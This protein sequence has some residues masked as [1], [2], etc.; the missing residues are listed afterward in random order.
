MLSVPPCTTRLLLAAGLLAVLGAGLAG[1]GTN[2]VEAPEAPVSSDAS[3]S[4]EEPEAAEDGDEEAAEDGEEDA[5]ERADASGIPVLISTDSSTGLIG[6]WRAGRSD[7]DDG[8]AIAMAHHA[9]ELDLRGVVVTFGNNDLEPQALVA[10]RIAAEL[11]GDVPVLR[12]ASVALTSP[13]VEW[14]DGGEIPE[15]CWNEGVAFMEEAI[16]AEP[17][18]MTILAIGPLTDLACLLLNRPE[19]A[20][21]IGQV[22]AI[23]GRSPEQSFAINGV[24]GLTDFNFVMD[25]R[26]AQLVLESEVSLA[27]MPFELTSSA[28]VP[29]ESLEVLRES[30]SP[31][32]DFFLSATEPWVDYWNTVF[33]EEGFHPWD[34]NAIYYAMRPEAFA[35]EMAGYELVSCPSAPYHDDEDNVCAGHG[36]DQPT[37][38]DKESAQLW[39][40][41]DTSP[42]RLT[43]C[44]A[45]ASDGAREG[46]LEAVWDFAR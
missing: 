30:P 38:L 40:S 29:A 11:E 25:V 13:Q 34:Q 8:L 37:S 26:A 27:L 45:Y 6:G 1:C 9:E 44:G 14:T 33:S 7:I 16:A 3:E 42:A 12:G 31:L 23:M 39:A 46:F 28:L 2:T 36:S 18:P 32:N 35:C 20:E 4:A 10:E 22:V 5:A 41:P 17:E 19:A 24:T 15:A 43:Y 21:G